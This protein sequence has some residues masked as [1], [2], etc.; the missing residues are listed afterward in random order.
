MSIKVWT[1]KCKLCGLKLLDADKSVLQSKLENHVDNECP[2]V[3]QMKQW[4][5]D[6]TYKGMMIAFRAQGLE[7]E[8]K[9]LLK[10]F[11]KEEIEEALRYMGEN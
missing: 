3:K 8:L 6:G 9:K 5:K 4:Q 1:T 2:T 7:D 10:H 11:K